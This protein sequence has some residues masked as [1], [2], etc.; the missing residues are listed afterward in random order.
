MLSYA[1]RMSRVAADAGEVPAT[2]GLRGFRGDVFR[3]NLQSSYINDAGTV[4]LYTDVWSRAGWV[5]FAKGP[6]VE[7]RPQVS[8]PQLR[9][10]VE[11]LHQKYPGTWILTDQETTKVLDLKP[12]LDQHPHG[13]MWWRTHHLVRQL[14]GAA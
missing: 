8:T 4:V 1:E 6:L 5:S 11:S 9:D 12:E 14:G 13:G 2:F 3:V 10:V 7:L